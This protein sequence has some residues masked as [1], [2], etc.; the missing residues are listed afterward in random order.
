MDWIIFLKKTGDRSQF[1]LIMLELP[2][3][4][5]IQTKLFWTNENECKHDKWSFSM[6]KICYQQSYSQQSFE[7]LTSAADCVGARDDLWSIFIKCFLQITLL[8][9]QNIKQD[10]I[11]IRKGSGSVDCFIL[12]Y[13]K[14]ILIITVH[15]GFKKNLFERWPVVQFETT[16]A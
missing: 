6:K 7:L 15:F 12:I 3:P 2:L 14:L 5:N 4:I 16:E 9:F 1:Y 13:F 10:P 8:C 11:F